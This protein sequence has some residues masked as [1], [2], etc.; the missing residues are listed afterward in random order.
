MELKIIRKKF[1]P[2]RTIGEFYIDGTRIGYTMEDFV[3]DGNHDGDLKDPGE[4]KVYGKTA[5]PCGRYEVIMSW[6]N[7]FKKYMPLI[8][9]VDGF[10]GIRIHGGNTEADTLGCPLLG[11][12][13][14]WKVYVGRCP[15]VNDKLRKALEVASKSGKVFIDVID[16]VAP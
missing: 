7:N 15:A 16:Q 12:D 5:I 13:T 8:C 4:A 11:E 3:R 14:D 2:T 10:E 6:S 1:F 9:K